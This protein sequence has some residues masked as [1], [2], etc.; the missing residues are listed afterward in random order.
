MIRI[1]II[2]LLLSGCSVATKSQQYT[3]AE[4]SWNKYISG[5]FM[6][7]QEQKDLVYGQD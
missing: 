1:M 3:A 7:E 6:T 4:R 2:A 5:Q